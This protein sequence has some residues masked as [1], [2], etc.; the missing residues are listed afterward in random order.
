M[1]SV[2]PPEV[3][4]TAAPTTTATTTTP[5]TAPIIGQNH[6]FLVMGTFSGSLV[7]TTA[8]VVVAGGGATTA[9]CGA[10]DGCTVSGSGAPSEPLG[11][12]TSVWVGGAVA[13]RRSC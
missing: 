3:A 11:L 5:A 10:G 1:L 6:F 4:P 2:F 13:V 12:I 7:T 9:T 8:G